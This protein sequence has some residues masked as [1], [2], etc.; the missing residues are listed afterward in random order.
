MKQS[1]DS[2]ETLDK[3]NPKDHISPNNDKLKFLSNLI[4]YF[5]LND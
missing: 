2:N 5:I 1:N 3:T 4:Q